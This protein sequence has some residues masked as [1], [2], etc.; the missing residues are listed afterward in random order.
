MVP[1]FTGTWESVDVQGLDVFLGARGVPYLKRL[2]A[3]PLQQSVTQ[4]LRH[5]ESDV[6]V[7]QSRSLL[8]TFTQLQ[9][10]TVATQGVDATGATVTLRARWEGAVWVVDSETSNQP[11]LQTRRWLEGEHMLFDV[12]TADPDAAGQT[13]TVRR[14]FRLVSR[15]TE[16]V[17]AAG[18]VQHGSCEQGSS[19]SLLGLSFGDKR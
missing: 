7:Q 9:R 3:V 19:W 2:V 8:S 15:T 13:V 17:P 10:A 16:G 1:C 6:L 4:A 5:E 14:R 12:S 11:A 18:E